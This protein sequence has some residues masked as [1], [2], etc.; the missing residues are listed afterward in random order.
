MTAPARPIPLLGDISLE[1]VQSIEHVLDG[2]FT[3]ATVVGLDGQLQHRSARPSHRIRLCGQLIGA[4]TATQLATLQHAASAGT[5]LT[6]AADITTALELQRV[7]ITWFRAAAVPGTLDTYRY[8]LHLAES[9]PLPPPA[10]LEP[11]G[12]LGDF[13]V[14][15]LGFDTDLLDDITAAAE[16]V[17]GAVDAAVDAVNAVQAL[18][19]LAD[20]DVPNPSGLLDPLAQPLRQIGEMSSGLAG[21]ARAL[22]TAFG[23]AG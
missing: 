2:G 23:G 18:A 4:A 13:G 9:P 20:L 17:A 10:E 19:A 12:G 5:E 14:G 1:L 7:V 21:A 6:F 3:A 16:Q 8:E 22:G 11:F 15:D